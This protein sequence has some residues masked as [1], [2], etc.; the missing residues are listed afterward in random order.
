MTMAPL[1]MPYIYI[2]PADATIMYLHANWNAWDLL[3]IV[4]GYCD[5]HLASHDIPP[6]PS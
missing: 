5:L 4:I 6:K 3:Y 2:C 1:L